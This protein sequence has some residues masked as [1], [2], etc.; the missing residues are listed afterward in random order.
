MTTERSKKNDE[1][2]LV[3]A[4][5]VFI[6]QPSARGYDRGDYCSTPSICPT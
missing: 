2:W 3:M 5:A 6:H 4:L 1:E